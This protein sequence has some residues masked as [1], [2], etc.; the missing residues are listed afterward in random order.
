MVKNINLH[1]VF[2]G[3]NYLVDLLKGFFHYILSCS[4]S[5]DYL[6]TPVPFREVGFWFNN[7]R[8]RENYF[9]NWCRVDE[10]SV[11]IRVI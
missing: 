2:L 11:V 9:S 4:G 7:F 5:S 8:P 1:D 10:L 3:V 6:R